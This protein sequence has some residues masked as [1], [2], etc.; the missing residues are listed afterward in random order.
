MIEEEEE[1]ETEE[2]RKN[3][4]WLKKH[5]IEMVQ[6]YPRQW[7]AVLERNVIA[8]GATRAEVELRAEEIAGE[9]EYSVYFIPQT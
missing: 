6:K 8:V 3:D 7:I 1:L 9:R 5:F 4:D 2:D